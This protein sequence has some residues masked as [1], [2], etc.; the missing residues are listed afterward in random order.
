MQIVKLAKTSTHRRG[1]IVSIGC[2]RKAN[3]ARLCNSLSLINTSCKSAAAIFVANGSA[4]Y[5]NGKS[6]GVSEVANKLFDTK[7]TPNCAYCELGRLAADGKI[8]CAKKGVVVAGYS[9]KRFQYSP[10]KRVPKRSMPLPK[11][12]ADDFDI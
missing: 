7:I 6:L 12:T 8:L 10:T 1:L 9:C 2:A 5:Y 3:G 11:F 4:P